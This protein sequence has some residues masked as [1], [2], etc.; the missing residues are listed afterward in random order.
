MGDIYRSS[1]V[2][3]FWRGATTTVVRAVMLG[4]VKMATYDKAK[5]LCEDQ[6]GLKKGTTANVSHAAA[7]TLN[8]H[9]CH[10]CCIANR[11]FDPDCVVRP[12]SPASPSP[13][14]SSPSPRPLT[15]CARSR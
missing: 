7:Q 8:A 13:A 9:P 1:G 6:L 5:L 15:F 3:G 14:T 10:P 2:L 11:A 4:A 12:S